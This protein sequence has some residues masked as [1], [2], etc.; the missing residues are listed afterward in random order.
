MSSFFV[1]LFLISDLSFGALIYSPPNLRLENAN[2]LV[3]I[4]G[5]LQSPE[6]MSLG[7]GWNQVADKNNLV[8]L[9][10]QVPEGTNPL[11]C[12]NWYLQENQRA[13]RGQLKY[14]FDEIEASQK[15]FQFKKPKVFLVGISSGATTVAG[16][17]SCFPN[18]FTSAAIHSGPSYGLAKNI[19]EGDKV[20][21]DGPPLIRPESPCDPKDFKG[22]LIV[23]HGMNDSKV[24]PSNTA[25]VIADFVDQAKALPT[26]EFKDQEVTYQM[27][28]YW[29]KNFLRLRFISI[30]DLGHAWS[31]NLKNLKYPSFVG[32]DAKYPTIVP[33]FK[34][35]G[36]SS[37]NLIWDFFN[38]STIL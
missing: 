36:P 25:Q 17:I 7:T 8:V 28:D 35:Q 5:C 3:V 12:W 11:G 38:Q 1:S 37:T 27:T 29:D 19:F 9:Y 22:S 2:L 14:L 21:K 31:G 23:L 4:H 6:S 33:F 32:P 16:M 20:L 24:N 10:P 30:Q 18:H 13:D 15:I 34:S 26:K